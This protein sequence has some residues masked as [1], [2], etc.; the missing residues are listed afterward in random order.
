MRSEAAAA[1]RD[2]ASKISFALERA[3]L[4]VLDLSARSSSA[5]LV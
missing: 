1:E 3:R 5:S 4:G 2:E